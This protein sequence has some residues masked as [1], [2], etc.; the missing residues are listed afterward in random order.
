MVERGSGT[1][2][3]HGTG[4]RAGQG[5]QMH[6]F[7]SR[8]QSRAVIAT[9]FAGLLWGC[10]DDPGR[11]PAACTEGDRALVSALHAAPGQVRLGG[12][13]LSDCLQEGASGDQ[14]QLVGTSFVEAASG[15]AGRARKRPE[16]RAALE[17][18]YLVAAAHRGG[19]H[20]QG[21]HDELLRR[22]DQEL[23]A[24]DTRSR[25]YLRGKRA[26]QAAG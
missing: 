3:E 16:G 4:I 19:E 24:I 11:L 7:R 20:T 23:T 5:E 15:L 18:G 13:R 22:L 1:Q 25:S 9:C 8:I 14:V 10:G 21:I 6:R 26:G 2:W 17:L 12:G